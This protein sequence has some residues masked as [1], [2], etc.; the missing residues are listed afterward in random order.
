MLLA[1]DSPP[2]WAAFEEHAF[3]PRAASLAGGGVALE[4]DA[5]QSSRN[6]A[7]A[8]SGWSG[9]GAQWSQLFGIPELN[10]ESADVTTSAYGLPWAVH[11]GTFGSDLYRESS[12]RFAVAR[13]VGPK[14]TF[15]A[16]LNAGWLDISN[17]NRGSVTGVDAG[18]LIQAHSRVTIGAVWRNLN[19]PKVRGYQ[20]R[21][22][23]SLTV[24][25]AFNLPGE[26]SVVLDVV[27]EPHHA[28]EYR[29][30]AEARVLSNVALQVGARVEPVRPSAG[31]HVK[32]GRW[33]F[34]YA[35]DLHP[36]LG[37]SHDVGLAIR[38]R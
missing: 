10:R 13:K 6:P 9:A 27:Q 19:D 3:G 18:V 37:V 16:S 20:D 1:T 11:A 14:L 2:L 8:A 30:G 28:A 35:G 7:L 24:G 32:A 23:E 26:A 5:W 33:H 38:F 4:G 21:L 34:Y 15:G 17:Y 31:V 22:A 12:L 36:D 29:M 25:A